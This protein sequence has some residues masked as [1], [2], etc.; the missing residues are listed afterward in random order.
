M[1]GG[2]YLVFILSITVIVV[3]VTFV[4]ILQFSSSIN[5]QYGTQLPANT[6]IFVLSSFAPPSC[7]PPPFLYPSITNR[8]VNVSGGSEYA[9]NLSIFSLP[10][11]IIQPGGTLRVNYLVIRSS[12]TQEVSSGNKTTTYH[13]NQ[14][15]YQHNYALFYKFVN[16]SIKYS[17]TLSS[18]G[19]SVY[20]SPPNEVTIPE[21]NSPVTLT[22]TTT[23]FTAAGTYVVALGPAYAAGPICSSTFLLTIGSSP[24][25]PIANSIAPPA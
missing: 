2:A 3:T 1:E 10:Q 9:T 13:F 20:V 4:L 8:I 21:S 5:T 12:D 17:G 16:S 19:L 23:P 15:I 25:I 18:A 22:I 24:Y 6:E 11:Y 7:P 14:S